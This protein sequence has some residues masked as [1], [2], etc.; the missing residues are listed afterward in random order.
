[1]T[2]QL[3]SALENRAAQL[4]AW[5]VDL[6]AVVRQGD[7]QVRRRRIA[8][9]GGLAGVLVVAGGIAAVAGQG[10]RN[11]SLPADQNA[12][13]LAYAV[14]GVIHSGD[15]TVDVGK[16]V[17]SLV[18]THWGFVF[19]TPDR[20]LYQERDGQ[21]EPITTFDGHPSRLADASRLVVGDDGLLT[22]WWDGRRIQSWPGYRDGGGMVDD[23]AKTNSFNAEKSWP[24]GDPPHVQ[25]V[26]DGHLWFWDGQDPMIAEVR[27][28]TTTA[29]WKDTNPP[30]SG[31]VVDAAGDQVLVHVD[32]GMA[33]TTANL[34]K[35]PASHQD[36]WTPGGDLADLKAQVPD[37]ASGDLAPD[38]KHWFSQ[39]TGQFAVFDSS[40]GHRQEIA[41]PGFRSTVP[42][43]WLGDDTIAALAES[44]SIDGEAMTPVSLLVCRVS[45]NT[46]QVAAKEVGTA[47]KVVVADGRP[48]LP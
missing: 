46:C 5:D 35:W 38:G 25:A 30:G 1:M 40:T 21:V 8:V 12:Q 4:E 41:H 9:A 17:V 19:S 14:G 23:L 42:Y 7:R 26:S 24:Q 47:G 45:T 6:D 37:V 22:A 36:G 44:P 39:D 33:V 20:R 11:T 29:G 13:P 3:R 28:M 32:D 18:S 10:H 27:P 48:S 2:G 34:L 15:D 16:K 43:Q 31:T